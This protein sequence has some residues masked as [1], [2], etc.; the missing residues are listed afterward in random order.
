M[1]DLENVIFDSEI[2][3]FY[4]GQKFLKGQYFKKF[5]ERGHM[6][7][8]HKPKVTRENAKNE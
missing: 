7:Y 8:S 1:S 4:C 2:Q 6:L 3:K 5:K